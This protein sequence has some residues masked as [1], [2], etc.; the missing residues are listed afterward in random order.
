M[1]WAGKVN[2]ERGV[3]AEDSLHLLLRLQQ[4]RMECSTCGGC[5]HTAKQTPWSK[6]D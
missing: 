4:L 2:Y 1:T 5:K 6:K 3:D